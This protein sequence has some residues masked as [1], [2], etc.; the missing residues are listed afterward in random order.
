MWEWRSSSFRHGAVF[1]VESGSWCRAWTCWSR[2]DCSRRPCGWVLP[3]RPG[4]L[5]PGCLNT[6]KIS[7][8][9][10][11]LRK[12]FY[13]EGLLVFVNWPRAMLCKPCA[14][15]GERR[16]SRRRSYSISNLREMSSTFFLV[17]CRWKERREGGR[18]EEGELTKRKR[19]RDEVSGGG[20][21]VRGW[22]IRERERD[23][24]SII[25]TTDVSLPIS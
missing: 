1:P 24:Q 12:V 15:S 2:T 16:L 13:L 5:Q 25:T 17:I 3:T 8:E 6:K 14:I 19:G 9:N 18:E 20:S 10:K 23:K 11:E 22:R 7:R 21:E 4:S